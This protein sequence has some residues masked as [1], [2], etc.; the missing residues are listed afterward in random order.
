M[1]ERIIRQGKQERLSRKSLPVALAVVFTGIIVLLMMMPSSLVLIFAANIDG[2]SGDDTLNGTAEADIINGFDG[3]DKLFGQ[4]GDDTLDGGNGDDEIYSG[5]GNDE[6]KDVNDEAIYYGNK[7]SGGPGNDSIH[8]GKVTGTGISYYLYGQAGSD[9]IE[10]IANEGIVYGGPDEDIIYCT[11]DYCA[12]NGNQGNDEI[13]IDGTE[14]YSSYA[15]GGSG[16]DK[17]YSTGS[18]ELKGNE[19]NDYLFGGSELDGGIGDD[20]LEEGSFYIGGPGA[21][22]FKCSFGPYDTVE[23]YNPKEG[24]QIVSP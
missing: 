4:G 10:V 8:V 7:V 11:A 13:Y 1:R 12:L 21:D 5:N 15:L 6:I 3:N 17:L 9:Y 16:N 22:T 2:T 24:D 14:I 18:Q 23:D 19:G 20:Y